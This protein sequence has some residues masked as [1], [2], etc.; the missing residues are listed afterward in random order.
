M[1]T[2]AGLCGWT[3]QQGTQSVQQVLGSQDSVHKATR[4]TEDTPQDPQRSAPA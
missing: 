2:G 3:P 1:R 4:D